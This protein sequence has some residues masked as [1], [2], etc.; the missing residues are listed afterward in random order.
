M[1]VR[2]VVNKGN[3][4]QQTWR[5]HHEETVVGRRRDCDLRILSAEVSRRHCLLSIADGYV[6]VEDLDSINGTLING[7]RVV[8]KQI[9]RPGDHLEIG[10]VAFIVDYELNQ[11]AQNR[12]AQQADGAAVEDGEVEVLPVAA[13]DVAARAVVATAEEEQLK[14]GEEDSDLAPDERKKTHPRSAPAAA[15]EEEPL[16]VLNEEEAAD[17]RLPEANAVRDLLA[18]MAKPKSRRPRRQR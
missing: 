5:L 7:R 16:A 14:A 3:T 2:L 9:L 12:L 18:Q 1:D 8:G 4:K 17:W 10:P 6:I 13:V 11:S 15:D